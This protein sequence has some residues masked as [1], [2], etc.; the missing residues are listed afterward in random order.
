[1]LLVA[2]GWWWD[3]RALARD[4]AASAAPPD[5]IDP[6]AGGFVVP[7]LPGQRLRETARVGAPAL[8]EA[9]PVT[10]SPVSTTTPDPDKEATRG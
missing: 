5:E 9:E 4:A 8:P 7:P 6:Y 2:L 1:M 3:N 10:Q